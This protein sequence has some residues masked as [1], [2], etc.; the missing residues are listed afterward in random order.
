M[1]LKM[2]YSKAKMIV[3][4][5]FAI[6]RIDFQVNPENSIEK[7]NHKYDYTIGDFREKSK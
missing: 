6:Y 5:G 4:I 1:N 3:E 7:L 2:V